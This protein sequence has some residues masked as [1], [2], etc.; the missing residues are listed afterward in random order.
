MSRASA[1]EKYGLPPL[2]ITKPAPAAP[3]AGAVWNGIRR[4]WMVDGVACD[5]QPPAPLRSGTVGVL[6]SVKV[7]V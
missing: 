1:R 3:P 5:P 4:L 6:P 2:N 7:E